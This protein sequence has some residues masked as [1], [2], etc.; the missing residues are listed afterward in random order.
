MNN[1][2]LNTRY[3]LVYLAIFILAFMAYIFSPNKDLDLY[4]WYYE[5]IPSMAYQDFGLYISNR[6]ETYSDFLYEVICAI[7]YKNGISLFLV[8][9][10]YVGLYYLLIF[11]IIYLYSR[12]HNIHLSQ[13]AEIFIILFSFF[14]VLP[15]LSFSIARMLASIDMLYIG[16]YLSLKKRYIWASLFVLLSLLYHYGS[17]VFVFMLLLGFVFCVFQISKLVRTTLCCYLLYGFVGILCFYSSLVLS[18]I[19]A[20]IV[21]A[22]ILSSRYQESIYMTDSLQINILENKVLYL[23]YGEIFMAIL[24]LEEIVSLKNE[25]YAQ[26]IGI[27][28]FIL[29]CFFLG[30]M[31]FMGDRIMMFIPI[32]NGIF[33]CQIVYNRNLRG[34]K[35]VRQYIFMTISCFMSLWCF[36]AERACFF[37]L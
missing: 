5:K 21:G 19:Q 33:M 37:L 27:A 1:R 30:S 16:F 4:R 23:K 2:P 3:N 6:I 15:I 31:Q 14:S 13:R 29:Y 8:N 10:F 11:K 32:F 17:V 34:K 25:K 24:L 36:Y 9:S 26:N 12:L 20:L 28:I 18:E 22:N 7:A 35:S